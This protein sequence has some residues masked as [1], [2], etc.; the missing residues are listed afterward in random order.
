MVVRFRHFR[1]KNRVSII[2]RAVG[3][4]DMGTWEKAVQDYYRGLDCRIEWVHL[5]RGSVFLLA[6]KGK[7]VQVVFVDLKNILRQARAADAKEEFLILLS[8]LIRQ[9]NWE[10]IFKGREVLFKW[11][12][13]EEPSDEGRKILTEAGVEPFS[14]PG[15]PSSRGDLDE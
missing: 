7:E 1:E 3:R 10:R 6:W 12:T 13:L 5:D 8:Y 14:L 4:R 2:L 15:F 9:S 11:M